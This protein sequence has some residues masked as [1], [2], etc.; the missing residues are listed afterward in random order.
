MIY[1]D[2]SL[3]SP[4]EDLACDEA[5]LDWAEAGEGG[6]VLRVWEPREMFVVVGYANQ[7][8]VEVNLPACHSRKVPVMAEYS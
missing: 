8:A 1:L 3:A 7:A 6:E 2:L 4:P 5:L